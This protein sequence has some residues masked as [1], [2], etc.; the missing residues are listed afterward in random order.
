MNHQ[1]LD[2]YLYLRYIKTI[3]LIFFF[4]CLI[5]WPILFPVNATAPPPAPPA[6]PSE[7]FDVISYSNS[8]D[9][10]N[11][12]YA[13]A[14]I[15]WLFFGMVL[16]V[17]ARETLFFIHLR[18]AWL[19]SPQTASRMSSR[20]VLFTDVPRE[21]L[22]EA[23]LRA[24]FPLIKH[25]WLASDTI[26]LADLVKDRGKSSNPRQSCFKFWRHVDACYRNLVQHVLGI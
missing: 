17:I 5:T 14:L 8:V 18:Q 19:L 3:T 2:G 13:H 20:T 11:R 26:E 23:T 4:G 10:P 16:F 12:Y 7:Q 6:A 9:S 25:I 1:S 22:N 15:A 21:Y 24:V